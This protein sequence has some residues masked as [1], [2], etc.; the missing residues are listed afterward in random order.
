MKVPCFVGVLGGNG[1]EAL[2]LVGHYADKFIFMDPH[3]V[4]EFEEDEVGKKTSTY[5]QSQPYSIDAECLAPSMAFTFL[6]KSRQEYEKL[7]VELYTI[8]TKYYP[9]VG[10]EI[11]SEPLRKTVKPLVHKDDLF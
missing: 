7:L 1:G 9:W 8:Q 4:Q 11:N 6:V 2:Y 5:F 10:F 3:Y